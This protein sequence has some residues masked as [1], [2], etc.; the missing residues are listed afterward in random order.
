[1]APHSGDAGVSRTSSKR[2]WTRMLPT[3]LQCSRAPAGQ[4]ALL[5]KASSFAMTYNAGDSDAPGAAIRKLDER[6][7]MSLQERLMTDLKSAMR[8]GDVP[9]REATRMLRA[10][11]LNEEI[12]IQR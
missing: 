1:M 11:I 8:A 6:T 5:F 9:R 4:Q 10:A 3:R 7:P 2:R 12:E